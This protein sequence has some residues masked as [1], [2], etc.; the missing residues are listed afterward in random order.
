[1]PQEPK[2]L[3]FSR[4]HWLVLCLIWLAPQTLWAQDPGKSV[5]GKHTY[6]SYC[7]TCHGATGQGDG[8]IAD[9][10]N[11]KP[12]DLTVLAKNNNGEFPAE[13]T[14]KIID[15]REKVKGHGTGEMPA[16]GDAFQAISDDEEAV[17]EKI[18]QLV[19]FLESIQVE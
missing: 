17:A 4:V 2:K 18:D 15:G 14:R 13:R 9:M 5:L 16:W 19:H 12:S 1:M 11:V 6:R 10:L 8:S 7:A 3:W